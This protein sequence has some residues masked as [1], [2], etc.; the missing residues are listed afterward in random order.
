MNRVQKELSPHYEDAH[1]VVRLVT[2][3]F[4]GNSAKAPHRNPD[5]NTFA[6]AFDQEPEKSKL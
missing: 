6:K 2:S 4:G 1:K 5:L 3:K